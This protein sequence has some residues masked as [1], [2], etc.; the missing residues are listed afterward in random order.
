MI[1]LLNAD[2]SAAK[3]LMMYTSNCLV[4]PVLVSG[5]K[6]LYNRY[7]YKSCHKKAIKCLKFVKNELK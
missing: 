5:K 6:C 1:L 2:I 4:E 7:V 3:N